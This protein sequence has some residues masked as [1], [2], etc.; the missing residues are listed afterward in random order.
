[1]SSHY[2]H[3]SDACQQDMCVALESAVTLATRIWAA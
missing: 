3:C 1:M 2:L